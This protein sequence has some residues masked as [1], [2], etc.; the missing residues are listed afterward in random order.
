MLEFKE[1]FDRTYPRKYWGAFTPVLIS[2]FY[3]VM[4]QAW[5]YASQQSHEDGVRVGALQERASAKYYAQAN[6]KAP[7]GGKLE[8]S[9]EPETGLITVPGA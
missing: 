6:S 1:W 3:E 7:K 5:N 8:E 2:A 4:E 9:L